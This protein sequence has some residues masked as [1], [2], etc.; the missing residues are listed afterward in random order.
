LKIY[1]SP[2]SDQIPV[3][4]IHAGGE[5]L[6]SK[7]NTLIINSVWNMEELL[8]Q[9]KKVIVVQVQKKGY[10][11]DCSNYRGILLLLN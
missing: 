3:E 7:I 8:E 5:K 9:W 10:K 4:L 1:K 11:T 6:R 2:G